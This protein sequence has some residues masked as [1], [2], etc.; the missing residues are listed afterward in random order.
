MFSDGYVFV[1]TD[2]TEKK[3]FEM[4]LFG[5]PASM[6]GQISKISDKT[7]IF[8]LRKTG[9]G[10][11]IM[12][13]VFLADGLPR[14][15]IK[16]DAWGGKYPGQVRIK[17]YYKFCNIP[18]LLFKDIYSGN[19]GRTL[20]LSITKEQTLDLITKFIINTRVFLSH[21]IV[22]KLS[23]E[24]KKNND[25]VWMEEKRLRLNFPMVW[26]MKLI[27]K[28]SVKFHFSPAHMRVGG[29]INDFVLAVRS[30]TNEKCAHESTR[31]FMQDWAIL[32]EI[33]KEIKAHSCFSS[34]IEE[35]TSILTRVS[36]PIEC[37][38]TKSASQNAE[39]ATMN[40]WCG[41]WSF[42]RNVDEKEYTPVAT[43][44]PEVNSMYDIRTSCGKLNKTVD[45]VSDLVQPYDRYDSASQSSSSQLEGDSKT[46]QSSHMSVSSQIGSVLQVP[47]IFMFTKPGSVERYHSAM[48]L[49]PFNGGLVVPGYVYFYTPGIPQP[50][51]PN[52]ILAAGGYHSLY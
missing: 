2:A 32:L 34:G 3:C 11:P 13:G 52:L 51:N 37:F 20:G 43:Y 1:C 15:H 45:Y 6:W 10:R 16:P 8:L 5:G 24:I 12:Y 50:P 21:R 7:A 4:N 33:I 29:T 22:V 27:T 17:Q 9:S 31:Y 28:K 46:C 47:Q 35:I 49:D 18:W 44:S 30:K 26:W 48:V 41:S 25:K 42:K 23:D 40:K 38:H 14:C 39:A 19:R 36:M